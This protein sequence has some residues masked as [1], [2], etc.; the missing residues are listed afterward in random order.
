MG[1]VVHY[2]WHHETGIGSVVWRQAEGRRRWDAT[3]A[4]TGTVPTSGAYRI[5][6]E[7]QPSSN[8]STTFADCEWTTDDVPGGEASVDCSQPQTLAPIFDA[9]LETILGGSA[10]PSNQFG[11]TNIA[12]Q[13]DSCYEIVL[14]SGG[15]GRLCM[16]REGVLLSFEVSSSAYPNAGRIVATQVATLE[17]LPLPH[18][19]LPIADDVPPVGVRPL[20]QIDLPDSFS[21]TR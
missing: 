6:T 17:A 13:D 3:L 11:D 19:V 18:G 1:F 12:G 14:P 10:V 16:D 15:A 8:L 20:S 2:E 9:L 21:L 7:F 5:Q 4:P